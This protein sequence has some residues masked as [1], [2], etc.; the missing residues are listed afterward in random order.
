MSADFALTRNFKLSDAAT[1]KCML[2]CFGLWVKN[3]ENIYPTSCISHIS[4]NYPPTC[5]SFSNGWSRWVSS[6]CQCTK[7]SSN[8]WATSGTFCSE[9]G[10]FG[11]P[12][13]VSR[14][15]IPKFGFGGCLKSNLD[16]G[17]VCS[18]NLGHEVVFNPNLDSGII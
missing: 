5:R 11:A 18:P 12:N 16:S 6:T 17:V 1:T 15:C 14:L 7:R 2:F 13:L 8:C 4:T 3:I 10:W 9:L